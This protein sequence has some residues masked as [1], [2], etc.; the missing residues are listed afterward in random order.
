MI[1]KTPESSTE[2]FTSR[3][4]RRTQASSASAGREELGAVCTK[5]RLKKPRMF[6][7]VVLN[8]DY[9]PMDFVV[10]VLQRFFHL[11]L[12]Q[13]TRLMLAVH[14]TGRGVCGV[15]SRE[16]AET[17]VLAMNNY[18]RAEKHPLLCVMEPDEP[19]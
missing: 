4:Q 3:T 6:K 14:T 1:E 9:T 2:R 19:C 15:F 10:H 5:P 11:S 18:A 12:E 7:V 16:I 17:K 13:A 8:D